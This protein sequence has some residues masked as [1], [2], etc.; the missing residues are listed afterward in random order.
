[1]IK[2]QALL[3]I[4]HIVCGQARA[5]L[6]LAR[7]GIQ[8]YAAGRAIEVIAM[9]DFAPEAQRFLV[10]QPAVDLWISMQFQKYFKTRPLT[11]TFG[12]HNDLLSRPSPWHCIHGIA[13]DSGCV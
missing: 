12:T 2:L 11:D 7:C 4:H 10:N 5:T 6:D 13:H 8:F 3:Y 9:I 1:M